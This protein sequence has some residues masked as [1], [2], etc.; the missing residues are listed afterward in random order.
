MMERLNLLRLAAGAALALASQAAFGYLCRDDKGSTSYQ[1]EPCPERKGT[2]GVVPVKAKELNERAMQETVKRLAK[3]T[4]ARDAAA[5]IS[6]LSHGLTVTVNTGS[7]KPSTYDYAKYSVAIKN[8]YDGAEFSDNYT[9]KAATAS[10][11]GRGALACDMMSS[12]MRGGQRF[13]N[14]DKRT[15]EFVL[16]ED[17]VKM[18]SIDAT[19]VS[20]SAEGRY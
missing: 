12:G 1:E 17:E 3:T 2:S 9:C 8:S 15:I 4:Q 5:A 20:R 18:I 19:V 16:E 13:R 11:P 14:Q 10:V 7:G 6:L